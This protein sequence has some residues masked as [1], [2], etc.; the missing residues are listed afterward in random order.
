MRPTRPPLH[1]LGDQKAIP[2]LQQ[3]FQS[4]DPPL[5]LSR[6]VLSIDAKLIVWTPR[7]RRFENRRS[8]A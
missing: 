1:S 7:M 8:K 6:Y 2:R 5:F 3:I 4:Y